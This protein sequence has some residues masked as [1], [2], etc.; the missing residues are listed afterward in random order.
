ME[1]CPKDNV[2]DRQFSQTWNS[3]S[4]SA[5]DTDYWTVTAGEDLISMTDPG[6]SLRAIASSGNPMHCH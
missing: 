3:S 6:K 1:S 2:L 4:P 5:L